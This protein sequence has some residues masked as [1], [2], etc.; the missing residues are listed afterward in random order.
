MHKLV[1]RG[2]SFTAAE[3]T[4]RVATS[5]GRLLPIT[6]LCSL[7]FF[8]VPP[9]GGK[10]GKNI[11]ITYSDRVSVYLELVDSL[12]QADQTVSKVELSLNPNIKELLT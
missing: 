7:F 10:R 1:K 4:F 9:G 11:G 12:L 5:T 2:Q 6:V 3:L 8:S